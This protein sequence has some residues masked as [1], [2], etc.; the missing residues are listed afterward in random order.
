[1][2]IRLFCASSFDTIP[3]STKLPPTSV[4][5]LVTVLE[6]FKFIA[7]VFL[8]FSTFNQTGLSKYFCILLAF[9]SVA[10]FA[11]NGTL[12][13][14]SANSVGTTGIEGSSITGSETTTR[15]EGSIVKST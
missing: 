12:Y 10:C 14:P 2:T 13:V 7:M 5:K 6:S 4:W 1:M 9:S 15:E 3:V 11:V 8:P